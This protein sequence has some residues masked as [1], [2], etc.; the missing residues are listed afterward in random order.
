VPAG[1]DVGRILKTVYERQLDGQVGTLE[2]A[3]AAAEEI[4][5]AR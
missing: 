5:A 2:E 4:L 1:P 3:V